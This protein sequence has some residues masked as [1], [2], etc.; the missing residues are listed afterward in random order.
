[1]RVGTVMTEGSKRRVKVG[2]VLTANRLLVVV[3]E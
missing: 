3:M 2:R 1:M